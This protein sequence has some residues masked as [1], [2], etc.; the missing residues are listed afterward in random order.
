M[1]LTDEDGTCANVDD[2]GYGVDCGCG[3]DCGLC[4]VVVVEVKLLSLEIQENIENDAENV[5]VNCL[6]CN[7]HVNDESVDH[8][9]ELLF[10]G[11]SV[12]ESIVFE[13]LNINKNIY[14][15]N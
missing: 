14:N 1:L 3:V 6:C 11:Y 13:D 10:A 9:S 2:C 8:Q 12:V 15:K 4:F 5:T 7:V